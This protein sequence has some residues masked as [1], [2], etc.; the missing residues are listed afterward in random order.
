MK[1][2]NENKNN[3]VSLEKEKCEASHAASHSPLEMEKKVVSK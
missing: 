2:R 1:F 3:R